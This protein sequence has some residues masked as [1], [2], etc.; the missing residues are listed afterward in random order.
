MTQEEFDFNKDLLKEIASKSKD[1][2][3]TVKL[4]QAD[5]LSRINQPANS[6]FEIYNL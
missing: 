1:L 4:T 2:R 6:A 3:Q 5:T